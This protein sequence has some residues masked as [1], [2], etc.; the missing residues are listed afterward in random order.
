[1]AKY[2]DETGLT[3]LWGKL[4]NAFQAKLVSGT[5]IK[6]INNESLLGSGN[7]SISSGGGGSVDAS[8]VTY[9][10]RDSTASVKDAL[11]DIFDEL[12]AK[13]YTQHSHGNLT[14]EGNITATAP[15]IANNDKLVINDYSANKIT[16]GPTFDGSTT[17]QFLSKKG[18][19]ESLPATHSSTSGSK[20][21]ASGTSY[22]TSGSSFSLSAGI[23][24]LVGQAEFPSSTSGR[25][26]LVWYAGSSAI[27]GTAVNEAP[28][29][30]VATR[31]QT[32]ALVKPTANTTYTLYTAQN[33]GSAQTVTFNLSYIKIA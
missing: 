24:I 14:S 29:S 5:N 21:I 13:A 11:D 23:Y 25:R 10:I 2:L 26:G 30:G 6:T 32:V 15:T 12:P 18:T 16:N 8:E 7:I 4:K 1:M 27:A 3:Y 22:V 20:S 19:W 17:N 28:V 31:I 9:T 33:S